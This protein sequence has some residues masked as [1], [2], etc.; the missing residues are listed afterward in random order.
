MQ[1]NPGFISC[2]PRLAD[3]HIVLLVQV[4]GA[5]NGSG[6][7]VPASVAVAPS[8]AGRLSASA[9]DAPSLPPGWGQSPPSDRGEGLPTPGSPTVPTHP[10]ERKNDTSTPRPQERVAVDGPLCAMLPR[11]RDLADIRQANAFLFSS[12]HNTS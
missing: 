8:V 6:G 12:R 2:D 1:A 10:A 7:S 9:L 3:L 11:Y 4:G 5:L